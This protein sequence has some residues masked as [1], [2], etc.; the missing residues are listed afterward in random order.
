MLRSCRILLRSIV[1][2]SLLFLVAVVVAQPTPRPA[3]VPVLVE[4]FTSEGC[5][6]CPPADALLARL[7]RDQP[8]PNA[9]I[10][11][12][13][14]HVDYWDNL[15]WHDRFSSH[16][17]TD[18]QSSYARRLR[19]DDIYTPQMVVDGTDQFTGNDSAH[20]LRAIAQAA[21]T[22]KLNLTLSPVTFDGT[23]L[24]GTVSLSP[25]PA[26]PSNADLYVAVVESTAS[27]QV[28]RG[29]NGGHTLQHVS[30]VR[31][32][33][34]IGT[35]A[36]AS[37]FTLEILQS[38]PPKDTSPAN[39]RVVIFIQHANQGAVVAAVASASGVTP[40][41]A[42]SIASTQVPGRQ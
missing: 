13:E 10:I 39:I 1:A 23:H 20:A 31:A 24:S 18:R 9:D 35:P 27:T 42:A 41:P 37:Q 21:H 33:Q 2:F 11:V 8:V 26:P 30:I 38:P 25:S 5:S 19:L 12:L 32:L 34:R 6:S 16:Q 22:P 40:T 29:E 7:Q 14:E 3:R 15:G 36:N 17:I 28:Q 4:L